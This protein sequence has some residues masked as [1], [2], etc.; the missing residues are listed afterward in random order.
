MSSSKGIICR[1]SLRVS[2]DGS[3]AEQEEFI[4]QEEPLEIRLESET[5]AVTMRTPGADAEL[6]AG[7][8]LSEGW[9]RSA[10]DLSTLTHCGRPAEEGS[11]NVLD[12]I[13]TSGYRPPPHRLEQTRRGTLVSAACGVCGRKNIDDLMALCGPVAS[14]TRISPEILNGC[15]EQLRASQK[16]FS[17]TGGVHAAMALNSEGELL[18]LYEDIG[19]H[20]AVDKVIGHLLL[21]RKL[22][23]AAVLFVSGR[24]SFEMVQKAA[25]AHIPVLGSISAA[26]SLAIALAEKSN[27]L[28]ASFVR[29]GHFT[30][31]ANAHRLI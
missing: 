22:E 6:A 18:A 14:S 31:Y 24:A 25:M 11:G 19:R 27:I 20:N 15:P 10:A 7:F 5:L 26:S 29:E 4:A 17:L 9:I 30:V 2:G 23:L 3:R 8:L 21:T 28:L 12:V 1:P 13:L 16:Q